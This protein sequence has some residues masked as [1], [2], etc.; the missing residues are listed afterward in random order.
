MA[1]TDFSLEKVLKRFA[2][3]VEVAPL[4]EDAPVQ[5][6][7]SGLREQLEEGVPLAL[8]GGSEKARSE[9]IIA[10]ILLALRRRNRHIMIYSGMRL[11]IDP[12]SGLVGECDFLVAEGIALPSLLQP[13]IL[14]V[15]E[16]KKLDIEA[17]LG[18]CAAQLVAAQKFNQRE[19]ILEHRVYGCVTTGEAWQ[20]MRLMG[21]R[22]TLD[23]ARYV[24][25]QPQHEAV[26][27]V[28]L[29]VMQQII[30]STQP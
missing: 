20:F 25:A 14:A 23:T 1:Y 19:G 9:F 5:P 7:E 22:L 17:G 29:G 24:I 18:Q 2:L 16:A 11:D 3:Q 27:A 4:F 8:R 12:E 28:L 15:L 10:P 26:V 13:P 6:L 30:D 21:Q